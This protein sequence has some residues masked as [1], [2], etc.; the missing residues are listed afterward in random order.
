MNDALAWF[1][2]LS[3]IEEAPW[4]LSGLIA[5]LAVGLW[6]QFKRRIGRL[7]SAI[8]QMINE[9]RITDGPTAFKQRYGAIFSELSG[10]PLLG[11]VWR[12]YASTLTHDQSTS[13][14]IGYTRRPK[15]TFNEQVVTAAGINLPFYNAVP[16]LLVGMG[17]LFSFVGLV[18]ALYFASR[19]VASESVGAAQA[20]LGE[21]L[22]VATFKFLTSITGL[23]TSLLFSWGEKRQL[24][25][26]QHRLQAFCSVLEARMAPITAESLMLAQLERTRSIEQHITRL[27]RA[28]YV[29]VPQALEDT[30][31]EELR[32]ALRPLHEAIARAAANF[33]LPAHAN[34]DVPENQAFKGEKGRIPP[35]E[36][37]VFVPSR[38]GELSAV[39]DSR[40]Q[41]TIDAVSR[42]LDR[43]R[44][45]GSRSLKARTALLE[46]TLEQTLDRLRDTR[47]TVR[48]MYEALDAGEIDLD[49][50]MQA[51]ES[52]D[53]TLVAT[54]EQLRQAGREVP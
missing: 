42:G 5:L 21:L 38:I 37:A 35:K 54:R 2:R 10:N 29:R 16:N 9:V 17:L 52:V 40:F 13:G 8:D 28:V 43:L 11:D 47:Q 3:A 33:S 45:R 41:K 1:W 20:A 25:E 24:Y 50:A 12:A 44:G 49:Q 7:S 53:Q 6:V 4:V 26:I 34:F 23:A 15:E 32:T 30:L 36:P 19:G 31:S 14:S 22:A 48:A 39:A 51:L 18:S 46:E 27:S